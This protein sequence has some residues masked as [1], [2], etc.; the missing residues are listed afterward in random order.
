MLGNRT[1]STVDRPSFTGVAVSELETNTS[2]PFD[3]R[4]QEE[5]LSLMPLAVGES[6]GAKAPGGC[7]Q[8]GRLQQAA[9]I[10]RRRI[11]C[12]SA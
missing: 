9:L 1:V 6:T 8:V 2:F 12:A 4:A 11:R 10:Y 7:Y 5:R 3:V